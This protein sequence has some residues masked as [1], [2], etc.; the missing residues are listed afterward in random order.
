[1]KNFT[2]SGN[3]LQF[4]IMK[5]WTEIV[6]FVIKT[7]LNLVTNCNIFIKTDL[8]LVTSCNTFFKKLYRI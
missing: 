5:N 4:F 1:M 3:K 6:I 8:N 2:E 7:E